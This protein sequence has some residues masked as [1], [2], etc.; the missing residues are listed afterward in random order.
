MQTHTITTTDAQDA[1]IRDRG[2]SLRNAT[3]GH[4]GLATLSFVDVEDSR[5]VVQTIEADGT[6]RWQE[7]AHDDDWG[8]PENVTGCFDTAP[9]S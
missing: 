5:I 9:E 6:Y 3:Q 1:V 2:L 7:M 8:D 4:W